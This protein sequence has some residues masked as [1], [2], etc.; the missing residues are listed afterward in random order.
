M[1]KTGIHGQKTISKVPDPYGSVGCGPW[2][3]SLEMKWWSVNFP[4]PSQRQERRYSDCNHQQLL[5]QLR[6]DCCNNSKLGNHHCLSRVKCNS[7]G[8]LRLEFIILS[9]VNPTIEGLIPSPVVFRGL[10]LDKFDC[11]ELDF[12]SLRCR[13]RRFS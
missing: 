6:L 4:Y 2:I 12:H 9:R 11:K 10:V 8:V 1:F 3:P 13:I 7:D 5:L